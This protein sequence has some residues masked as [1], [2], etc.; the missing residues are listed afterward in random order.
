MILNDEMKDRYFR[1]LFVI[2]CVFIFGA[3]VFGR[4]FSLLHIN[5][6]VSPLFITE[7]VL[8]LCLPAIFMKRKIFL[9]F[10]RHFALFTFFYFFVSC[11]YFLVGIIQMNFFVLRD[12]TLFVYIIFV[13]IVYIFF[14]SQKNLNLFL[15]IIVTANILAIIMGRFFI[16]QIYPNILLKNIIGS[17]KAFNFGL[18]YGIAIAFLTPAL[19]LASK[20][21]HKFILL[22]LLSTNIYMIII[23][24]ER[25]L[26]FAVILLFFFLSFASGLKLLKSF[27]YLFPAFV[28]IV[29]LLFLV[30]FKAL[31]IERAKTILIKAETILDVRR[32]GK[33]YQGALLDNDSKQNNKD[34]VRDYRKK[35]LGNNIKITDA[36][37][38]KATD[39]EV[40]ITSNYR[41]LLK[42]IKN[43]KEE[44]SWGNI[45]W[46][47]SIWLQAID[48]GMVSPLFGRGFGIQ[49]EY[50]VWQ[51]NLDFLKVP[52]KRYVNTNLTPAHNHL[53]TIFYKMGILGLV[54]FLLI[55]ISVFCFAYDY[56]KRCRRE[57]TKLVLTGALGAFV[58]W[59]AM[60][61]FFD[62]ID[63]PYASIFLWIFIGLIFAVIKYDS[64]GKELRGA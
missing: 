5:L 38:T 4:A 39:T 53:V 37:N 41:Q 1:F 57:F 59:H 58:F 49:P 9:E 13:P 45:Y 42:D 31:Q 11:I 50:L 46:R 2:V 25:T 55:N 16:F 14:T 34:L 7:V 17:M 43:I 63:S 22:A 6:L 12:I 56:L 44:E 36:G 54:L 52:Y 15:L 40:S 30:D 35:A 19:C 20:R 48:F 61:L 33:F 29:G 60:A 8:L 21:T 28:I 26:W 3:L 24:A 18:N 64:T 23:C 62:I 51:Y 47:F 27:L 32:I 10:P